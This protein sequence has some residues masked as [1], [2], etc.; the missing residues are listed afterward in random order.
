MAYD[1]ARATARDRIRA[2]LGDTGN[3]VLLTGG[4]A[5]YNAIIAAEAT[6]HAACRRAARELAG[7]LAQDPDRIS[8]AGESLQW[9]ERI[10]YLLHIANGEL[11]TG[12]AGDPAKAATPTLGIIT[13]GTTAGGKLR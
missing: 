6:E 4:E 8:S 7:Q 9:S 3:T 5:S 10:S 1:A 12:L 2:V 13:A 11:G